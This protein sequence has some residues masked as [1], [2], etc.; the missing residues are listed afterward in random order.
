[1]ETALTYDGEY[2]LLMLLLPKVSLP[3]FIC[4]PQHGIIHQTGSPF[5]I[6]L[7]TEYSALRMTGSGVHVHRYNSI[8]GYGKKLGMGRIM[9]KRIDEAELWTRGQ[10]PRPPRIIRITNL[11]IT[12]PLMKIYL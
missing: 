5:A 4:I 8:H 10:L 3:F 1:M 9:R 11:N 12:F 7:I 2:T 6:R